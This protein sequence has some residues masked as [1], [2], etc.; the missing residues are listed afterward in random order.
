MRS[1]LKLAGTLAATIGISAVAATTA[2]ARPWAI[3]AGAADLARPS[4][5]ALRSAPLRR[6]RTTVVQAITTAA[7][8]TTRRPVGAVTVTCSAGFDTRHGGR[9]C[10]ESGSVTEPVQDR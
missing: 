10:I 8:L 2:D 1:S 4:S 9:E 7:A 6:P 3:M 5:A